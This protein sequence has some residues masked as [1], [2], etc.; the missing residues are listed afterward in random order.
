VLTS[1]RTGKPGF[2][3]RFYHPSG[4]LKDLVEIFRERGSIVA[5]FRSRRLSRTFIEKIMLVVT[6]VNG[7]RYCAYGHTHLALRSGVE[8]E[9]IEQLMALEIGSFPPDQAIA[10]AF[11]Q[12]SAETGSQPD[13][14]AVQRLE[15]YYGREI[16]RDIQNVIRMITMGNLSGNAVDAFLSRLAG[17]PAVES[18]LL[19]ELFLFLLL[20]PV[21]IPL[22]L[23]MK[24][25][26]FPDL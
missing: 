10:L 16:S 8:P 24:L 22:L 11:A 3:K 7:C 13:P 15:D 25:C 26:S 20:A 5:T 19:S 23:M 6:R 2:N 17:R 4:F 12:H 14:Q 1:S 18:R 21:L 9:E